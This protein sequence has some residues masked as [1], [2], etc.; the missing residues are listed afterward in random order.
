LDYGTNI[1]FTAGYSLL[2][3]TSSDSKVDSR[4]VRGEPDPLTLNMEANADFELAFLNV[5]VSLKQNI[6]VDRLYVLGG[7]RIQNAL[8]AKLSVKEAI[9]DEGYVFGGSLKSEDY[10]YPKADIPDK[11]SI[12]FAFQAG[13]L[14][15]IPLFGDYIIAPK[16]NFIYPFNSLVKDKSFKIMSINLGI[17]FLYSY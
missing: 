10:I 16:V 1:E 3:I 4:V 14:Y 5:S 13:L 17:Q 15:E 8:I 6:L 9:K 11:N 12:L 7:L 2:K